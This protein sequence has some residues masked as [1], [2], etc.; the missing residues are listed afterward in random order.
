MGVSRVG[1]RVLAI[2]N[3]SYSPDLPPPFVFKGKI[4]SAW[5]RKSE[6][7]RRLHAGRVRYPGNADAQ[8]DFALAKV[9]KTVPGLAL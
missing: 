8:S 5:R 1:E 7:D 6:P 3:F 4:V 9:A 2:V